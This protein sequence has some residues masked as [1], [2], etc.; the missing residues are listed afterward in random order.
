M[1]KKISTNPRAE[2]ARERKEGV[3]KAAAAA[4]EKAIEDAKWADQGSTAGEKR[5]AEKAAKDAEEAKKRAERKALA[6]QEDAETATLHNRAKGVTNAE[7]ITRA[8]LLRQQEAA[9]E[10]RRIEAERVKLEAMKLA[11]QPELQLNLNRQ[12]SAELAKDVAQYGAGHVIHASGLDATLEAVGG[13]ALTSSAS[14]APAIDLHPEKRLKSAFAEYEERMMP[15]VKQE[16][17]RLKLSQYKQEIFKLWQKVSDR[18]RTTPPHERASMVAFIFLTESFVAC[19]LLFLFLF[20]A[21]AD[22][23]AQ[24]PQGAGVT[25][26]QHGRVEVWKLSRVNTHAHTTPHKQI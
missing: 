22:E 15:I 2:A 3:K 5:K 12:S 9:D 4:H 20:P 10:A 18:D 11:P 8:Q 13:N 14:S 19:L 25:L 16:N 26:T 24:H 6:A 21:G 7:K 17:P 23:S 1:P